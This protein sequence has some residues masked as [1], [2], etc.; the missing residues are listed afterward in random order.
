MGFRQCNC[1]IQKPVLC[2]KSIGFCVLFLLTNVHEFYRQK[3]PSSTRAFLRKANGSLCR[4]VDINIHRPTASRAGVDEPKSFYCLHDLYRD[5]SNAQYYYIQQAVHER[6]SSPS[7]AER[8]RWIVTENDARGV[9]RKQWDWGNIIELFSIRGAIP[10]FYL[11]ALFCATLSTCFVVTKIW[12][13]FFGILRDNLLYDA[14]LRAQITSDDA[15]AVQTHMSD[16]MQ[17]INSSL[18]CAMF[19]PPII[20]TSF[21]NIHNPSTLAKVPLHWINEKR[22]T[23]M[24]CGYWLFSITLGWRLQIAFSACIVEFKSF[25]RCKC[26]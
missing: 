5:T 17:I 12:I 3:F 18:R 14:E 22:S 19:F 23:L 26:N 13:S 16:F 1:D 20:N 21:Y 25:A 4:D 10:L 7:I 8:T 2:N 6:S 24:V 11:M 15:S 9:R